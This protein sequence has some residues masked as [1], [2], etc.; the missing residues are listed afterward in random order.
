MLPGNGWL[1]GRGEGIIQSL[2]LR[3]CVACHSEANAVLDVI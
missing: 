1:A 2:M 3:V